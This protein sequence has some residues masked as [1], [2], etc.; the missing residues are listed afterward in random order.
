MAF[1]LKEEKKNS[2][3]FRSEDQG[4]FGFFLS[5]LCSASR[6]AVEESV[7]AIAVPPPAQAKAAFDFFGSLKGSR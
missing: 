6:A 4:Q 5:V 1:Q 7:P 2:N 3:G